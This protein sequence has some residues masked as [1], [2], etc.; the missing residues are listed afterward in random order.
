M[1][2]RQISLLRLGGAQELVT[3]LD[4]AC[5]TLLGECAQTADPSRGMEA[6]AV[7]MAGTSSVGVLRGASKDP[8]TWRGVV[9]LIVACVGPI[10]RAGDGPCPDASGCGNTEVSTSSLVLYHQSQMN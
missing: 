2:M 10:T 6:G 5:N 9:S 8:A 7:P 1:P 3:I 4:V